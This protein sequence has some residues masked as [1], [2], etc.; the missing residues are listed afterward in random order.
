MFGMRVKTALV[1]VLLVA[2][3]LAGPAAA[4]SSSNFLEQS[5]NRQGAT[6][7]RLGRGVTSAEACAAAC[8]GDTRCMAWTY[9]RPGA[10]T[11]TGACELKS[12]VPFPTASPCCVSGVVLGANQSLRANPPTPRPRPQARPVSFS[13]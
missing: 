7:E 2:P 5:M 11:A 13:R 3:I 1:S 8:A 10:G 6:Y 9:F 12:D 4:G